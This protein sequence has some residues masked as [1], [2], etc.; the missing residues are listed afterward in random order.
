MTHRRFECFLSS[1]QDCVKFYESLQESGMWESDYLYPFSRWYT[2]RLA[3][4][5]VIKIFMRCQLLPSINFVALTPNGYGN[6]MCEKH[7]CLFVFHRFVRSS[8]FDGWSR[9]RIGALDPFFRT[10]GINVC[11]C[12]TCSESSQ[13]LH[14]HQMTAAL[15]INPV[16]PW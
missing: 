16:L 11:V 7:C 6:G 15:R 12:Y 5:N 2:S 1:L 8:Y 10:A 14:L 9:C 4:L 13:V 3:F